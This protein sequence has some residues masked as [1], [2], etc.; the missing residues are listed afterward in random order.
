[1]LEY[2]KDSCNQT[3]DMLYYKHKESAAAYKGLTIETG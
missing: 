1:V 3:W 2:Q